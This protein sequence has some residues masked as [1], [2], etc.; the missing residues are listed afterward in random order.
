MIDMTDELFIGESISLTDNSSAVLSCQRHYQTLRLD[1]NFHTYGNLIL[2][3]MRYT[4]R[5]VNL[6]LDSA[7]QIYYTGDKF[8]IKI[9]V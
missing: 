4:F 2:Y 3:L 8:D 1:K 7:D 9:I 5:M 6:I